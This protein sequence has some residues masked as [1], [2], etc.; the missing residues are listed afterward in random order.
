MN[1]PFMQAGG[2]YTN[3]YKKTKLDIIKEKNIS[4]NNLYVKFLYR[5]LYMKKRYNLTNINLA[6]FKPSKLYIQYNLR[7]FRKLF[8]NHFK[9]EESFTVS[10][11]IFD[12]TKNIW[13][14]SFS[15]FKCGKTI[16]RYNFRTIVNDNNKLINYTFSNC[17]RN[18]SL[19][20][21]I[22]EIQ[23]INNKNSILFKS[24]DQILK[25]EYDIINVPENSIGYTSIAYYKEELRRVYICNTVGSINGGRFIFD[26]NFNQIIISFLYQISNPAKYFYMTNDP[27]F[28]IDITSIDNQLFNDTIIFTLFNSQGYH[29]SIRTDKVN[30]ENEWFWLSNQLMKDLAN[31]TAIM[32]PIMIGYRLLVTGCGFPDKIM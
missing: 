24:D 31:N 17:D 13:P 8:L 14:I 11:G 19:K 9:Y 2:Y 12:G 32:M 5:V 16:D 10:A 1:P 20:E 3:D 28:G 15:I 4:I 29:Y 30:I 18:N 22:L 23:A 27:Y 26:E 25:E 7:S 6:I 21:N